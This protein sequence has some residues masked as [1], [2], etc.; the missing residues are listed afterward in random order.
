MESRIA[1]LFVSGI[2]KAISDS[3]K[4][5]NKLEKSMNRKE[6]RN[7][8]RD[9]QAYNVHLEAKK[10]LDGF[11]QVIAEVE[12]PE[13][14][15]SLYREYNEKWIEFAKKNGYKK[16]YFE[17]MFVMDFK[18]AKEFEQ[19]KDFTAQQLIQGIIGRYHNIQIYKNVPYR[20]PADKK[21]E[22]NEDHK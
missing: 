8:R 11:A 18:K 13:S 3:L 21:E 7:L 22:S 20:K 19:T 12:A 16:D 2:Y 17:F 4:D 6:L 5:L 10:I 14:Y 9:R 1:D 15:A